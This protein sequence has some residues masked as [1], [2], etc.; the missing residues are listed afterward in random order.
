MGF[1]K[2]GKL[3]SWGLAM[4]LP[5]MG[6]ATPF[7]SEDTTPAKQEESAERPDYLQS[8]PSQEE[9]SNMSELE[10]MIQTSIEWLK[11]Y[12]KNETDSPLIITNGSAKAALDI[13]GSKIDMVLPHYMADKDGNWAYMGDGKKVSKDVIIKDLHDTFE[14]A[15]DIAWKHYQELSNLTNP[16]IEKIFANA[17]RDAGKKIEGTGLTFGDAFGIVDLAKGDFM[18]D[19]TKVWFAPLEGGTLAVTYLEIHKIGYSPTARRSDAIWGGAYILGHELVH[20]NTKLQGFPMP[21]G[22]DIEMEAFNILVDENNPFQFLFHGYAKDLR[23]LAG[24]Y[25]GIDTKEAGKKLIKDMLYKYVEFDEEE[26]KNA[27]VTINGVAK[28]LQKELYE[29]AYPEYMSM[30]PWWLMMNTYLKN[31]ITP[32]EYSLAKDTRP[33]IMPEKEYEQFLEGKKEAIDKIINDT[34]AAYKMP[35]RVNFGFFTGL[36]GSPFREAIAEACVAAGFT[37]QQFEVTYNLALQRKLMKGGKL[38]YGALTVKDSLDAMAEMNGTFQNIMDKYKALGKEKDAQKR[39]ELYKWYGSRLELASRYIG[40]AKQYGRE[41]S[42]NFTPKIF[43]P[44]TNLENF[45]RHKPAFILMA[46]KRNLAMTEEFDDN[47]DGKAEYTMYGYDI[48]KGL[49]FENSG[50]DYIEVHRPGETKPCVI[51]FPSKGSEAPDM[52]LI[53]NDIPGTD[54]YGL[55]DQSEK[56]QSAEDIEAI[57][58]KLPL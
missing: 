21:L 12:K 20:N 17:K 3:I 6:P 46:S 57:L 43:D 4:A 44:R 30:R 7:A 9:L 2:A 34:I 58:W 50:V 15:V 36:S 55:F 54:D 24:T 10:K 53:D 56:V 37:E 48:A 22:H 40:F 45:Y 38:D 31:A 41:P 33:K 8:L 23:R 29:E 14:N 39:L 25:Y 42:E 26:W 5:C 16:K 18:P 52:A 47:K 28:K 19:G 51:A 32:L 35:Q 11:D 13:H 27:L 49:G 1:R